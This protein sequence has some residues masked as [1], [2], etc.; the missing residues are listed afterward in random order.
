MLRLA[1]RVSNV[2]P[3]M[4]NTYVQKAIAGGVFTSNADIVWCPMA[5]GPSLW[6]N[7]NGLSRAFIPGDGG[8]PT[9]LSKYLVD[10]LKGP[11]TGSTADDDPRLMIFSGGIGQLWPTDPATLPKITDPLKQKG[12]PNGQDQ[13]K[14]ETIEGVKPLDLLATYSRINPKLL[15]RAES[16]MMMNYGEVA[17]L[18]AEASERSIGGLTPAGAKTY[19]EA[20]VKASMQMYTTYDA[21]FAVSD[22][23]V[24]TYLAAFPYTGK[25]MIYQQLW[26]SKFMNWWEAW[27]DWRRTGYPQ[28]VPI[29]YPGNQTGG[30]IPQRVVYPPGEVGG[31]PNFAGGASA[32]DLTTKVWWAGGPE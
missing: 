24:A 4:A 1:M 9:W 23:Q 14:L 30:K 31:N 8:Q 6:T 12:M 27:S 28:L 19:Y 22:G 21:S 13:D 5:E 16:Y 2:D 18:L 32:N 29:N 26:A 10:W 20:G 3:A 11:N 15:D 7:Q 17:L 25:P